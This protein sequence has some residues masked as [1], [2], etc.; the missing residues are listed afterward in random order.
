MPQTYNVGSR[1]RFVTFIAWMFILLGAF[2]CEWAVIQNATQS[3]WA[4]QLAGEKAGL[5]WLTGMLVRYL[6]WVFYC[7]IA[8]SL[9]MIVCAF[10]LLRRVEW[11]RRVFIGLLMVAIGVD[12]A[13]LW[14]QQEFIHLL[15][16][17][18]L[19]QVA[20]PVQAAELFGGVVTAARLLAGAITVV[21]S[22]GL[23]ATI[24]RLMSP[25]VRQEF[26]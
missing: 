22:V 8:L 16:D 23:V 18:T 19:H 2:A 17:S 14:L 15:V 12:L 25:A 26:A 6:P 1:S 24:R 9:A 3:S 5:P 13:G 7:A 20:L 21:A 10:G 4:A 11:A